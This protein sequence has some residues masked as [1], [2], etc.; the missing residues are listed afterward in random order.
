MK[1]LTKLTKFKFLNMFNTTYKDKN[2]EIHEWIF[3]SRR[4]KPRISTKDLKNPDAVIIVAKHVKNKKL[5]VIKEYRPALGAYQYS[6]PAGLVDGDESV[7]STARRE[8]REETGLWVV[9][10]TYKSQALTSSAGMTDEMISFVFTDCIGVIS[11]KKNETTEDIEVYLMSPEDVGNLLAKKDVIID[12][13]VWAYLVT[14]A[15][16]GG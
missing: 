9:N 14:F 2:G 7:F 16:T 12:A 3:S 4:K 5:V 6:L 15:L 13:R 1:T 10:P 8:L 11:T